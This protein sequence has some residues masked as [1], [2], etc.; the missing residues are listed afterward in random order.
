MEEKKKPAVRK[1]DMGIDVKDDL[2][3]TGL[4]EDFLNLNVSPLVEETDVSPRKEE[5][6]GMASG[7]NKELISCLSNT[8]VFVRLIPKQ[9]GMFTNPKHEYAGNMA[10]TSKKVFT[11]PVNRKGVYIN[12]LTNAEKDF[13][14]AA[15]GLEP[16]AL[17]VY[18]KV[19]NYWENYTV[20]LYKDENILDLSDP[21]QYIDYKVLLANKDH[22]CPS[23]DDLE[24]YFKATYL[25]VI[26]KENE[27]L[28]KRNTTTTTNMQAYMA[29]GAIQ[30]NKEKLRYV[31]RVLQGQDATAEADVLLP[32]VESIMN[33]NPKLFLSVV[34]DRY[35]DT[36]ILIHNAVREK[37]I[38]K[39]GDFYY[40]AKDSTPLCEPTEEPTIQSAAKFLNAP[41][42]QE[43]KFS[44]EACLNR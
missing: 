40:L 36:K 3:G 10:P 5:K 39:V 28:K 41:R 32:M 38:S 16:N 11:V 31:I 17:S 20:T 35:M 34:E 44:I 30:E 8:R 23:V 15:M 21:N 33:T 1:P 43:V 42:H 18:R 9:S 14:E 24:S 19:D 22:I 2:K 4:E 25:Y 37:I 27:E 13:L 6:K 29:L 7:E 12:V 26:V